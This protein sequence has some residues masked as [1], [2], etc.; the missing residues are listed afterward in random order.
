MSVYSELID[1]TGFDPAQLG[2]QLEP[3]QPWSIRGAWEILLGHPDVTKWT[4]S[5]G[6]ALRDLLDAETQVI[7]Q[8]VTADEVQAESAGSFMDDWASE[9]EKDL[10]Y[11]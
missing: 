11:G 4:L 7:I 8:P 2:P 5:H 1:E 3:W 6:Q 9:A 10:G